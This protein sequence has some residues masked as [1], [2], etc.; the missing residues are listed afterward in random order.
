MI[1]H[2]SKVTIEQI[3]DA[4]S[5][6]LSVLKLASSAGLPWLGLIYKLEALTWRDYTAG[7]YIFFFEKE[8]LSW[9]R[10]SEEFAAIGHRIG[11]QRQIEDKVLFR[12]KLE[13]SQLGSFQLS[14]ELSFS[15][16]HHYSN[17][18][19]KL[20]TGNHRVLNDLWDDCVHSLAVADL[21][22]RKMMI[23]TL[24]EMVGCVWSGA[25]SWADW[26]PTKNDYSDG[27]WRFKLTTGE[28]DSYLRGN[29]HLTCRTRVEDE[30]ALARHGVATQQPL[31]GPVNRA[32]S[33]RAHSI[34][35][36]PSWHK[37]V[38]ELRYNGQV[39]RVFR[40][41]AAK[42][43]VP[44]LDLFESNG[45]PLRLTLSG[46]EYSREE[47]SDVRKQLNKNNSVIEFSRDGYGTGLIWKVIE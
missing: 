39:I 6:A 28:H 12:I 29:E 11:S 21:S 38:G 46:D 16:A 45:W 34:N 1:D 5:T 7:K 37:D 25:V 20:A 22:A 14:D 35:L 27:R 40:V 2:L 44:V 33:T 13:T 31:D 18:L 32:D 19:L 3:D 36:L 15:T 30:W 4:F 17:H 24:Y 42:R 8:W 41:K 23:S 10:Y 47:I 43:I 26:D 9:E